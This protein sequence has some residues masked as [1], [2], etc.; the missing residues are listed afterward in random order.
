MS[1]E[2][3][4]LLVEDINSK[5]GLYKSL[6][7]ESNEKLEIECRLGTYFFNKFD[8]N[9][10]EIY[11][12]KLKK[13]L[14]N[15]SK[16]NIFKRSKMI[17]EDII[18]GEYRV[19]NSKLL[20]KHKLENINIKCTEGPFDIRLTISKEISEIDKIK[21]SMIKNKSNYKRIKKRYSYVYKNLSYDLTE[22]IIINN[23][24]ETKSYEFEIE[25]LNIFEIEN[26]DYLFNKIKDI[27]KICDKESSLFYLYSI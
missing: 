20:K 11:F 21:I 19:S 15:S 26:I 1:E 25:I 27:L 23:S 6:K 9:I 16:K 8:S 18:E 10:T 22:V 12:N 3:E 7:L 24:L 5:L 4:K 17:I 14:D 2:E 13:S